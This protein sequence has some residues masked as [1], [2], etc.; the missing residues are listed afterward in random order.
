MLHTYE[1]GLKNDGYFTGVFIKVR[2]SFHYHLRQKHRQSEAHVFC[3][4][5]LPINNLHKRILFL[6]ADV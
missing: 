6:V 1:L 4:N 2:V 5:I 3:M